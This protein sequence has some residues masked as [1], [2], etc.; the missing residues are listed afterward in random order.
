MQQYAAFHIENVRESK[1]CDSFTILCGHKS[2][3]NEV[4]TLLFLFSERK[5]LKKGVKDAPND[6]HRG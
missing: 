2:V 5:R 3:K 4:Y 6:C 1:I